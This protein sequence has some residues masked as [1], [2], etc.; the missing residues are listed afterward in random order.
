MD[1][2]PKYQLSQ[3]RNPFQNSSPYFIESDRNSSSENEQGV[4]VN[5]TNKHPSDGN[6]TNTFQDIELQPMNEND[7]SQPNEEQKNKKSN[8]KTQQQSQSRGNYT[9]DRYSNDYCVGNSSGDCCCFFNC[10]ECD[11]DCDD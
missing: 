9:S 2:Q 1:R 4:Q 11:C 7:V 5:N 6:N 3:P 8:H 10:G